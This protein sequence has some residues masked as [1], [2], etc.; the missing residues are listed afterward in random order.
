V[1]Q[2]GGS[3]ADASV[4]EACDEHGITMICNQLRLFHH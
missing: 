3:V 2:P 4:V 1:V